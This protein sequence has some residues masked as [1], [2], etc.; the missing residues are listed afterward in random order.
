MILE[1]LALHYD[2]DDIRWLWDRCILCPD[3]EIV[4]VVPGTKPHYRFN[5]G[6]KRSLYE[7]SQELIENLKEILQME[8]D[9][10]RILHF[11]HFKYKKVE[12]IEIEEGINCDIHT[13]QV[14]DEKVAFPIYK[15]KEIT[16]EKW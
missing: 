14:D 6:A 15:P 16:W 8:D 1:I 5:N 12:L 2:R 9:L 13:Y 11:L 10:A 4:E 3:L 7:C